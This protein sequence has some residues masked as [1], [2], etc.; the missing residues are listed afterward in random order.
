MLRRVCFDSLCHAIPPHGNG[1]NKNGVS[2][3][4]GSGPAVSGLSASSSDGPT[5]GLSEAK[6][7][8]LCFSCKK[9]GHNIS[10]CS[11]HM[12]DRVKPVL[13]VAGC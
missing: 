9:P 2:F 11:A 5:S 13:L 10:D 4:G 7:K 8:I 6:S 1:F 12:K 3:Q